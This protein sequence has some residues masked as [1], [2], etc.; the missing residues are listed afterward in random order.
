LRE[1]AARVQVAGTIGSAQALIAQAV[2]EQRGGIH[3]FVLHDREEAAY[4]MNDLEALRAGIRSLDPQGRPAD[5]RRDDT[6]L[7][8][9]A[10]SRSPYDPE[11]HHDGE[12]V[13]R[14]EVLEELMK[15]SAG[16]RSLVKGERKS[17]QSPI[18]SHQSPTTNHQSPITN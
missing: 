14:T 11:G 9:P 15:M 6:L 1:K 13:T 17:G 4:F 18:T 16:E 10:P 12:R 7:F 8:F 5:D 2:I 3:V